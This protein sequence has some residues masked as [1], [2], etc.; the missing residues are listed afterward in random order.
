MSKFTNI[1]LRL[2]LYFSVLTIHSFSKQIIMVYGHDIL[3][4]ILD[5]GDVSMYK[6][7]FLFAKGLRFRSSDLI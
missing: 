3:G 1:L 7:K 5:T 2:E 4:C 6:W